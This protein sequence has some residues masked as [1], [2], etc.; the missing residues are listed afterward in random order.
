MVERSVRIEE[1]MDV[2]QV[3]QNTA[4]RHL[5][6]YDDRSAPNAIARRVINGDLLTVVIEKWKA[7]QFHPTT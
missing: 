1:G 2:G 5:I 3:D 6:V 7:I 4:G